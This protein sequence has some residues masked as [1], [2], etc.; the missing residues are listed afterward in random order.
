MDQGNQNDNIWH[1]IH[2]SD[3]SLVLLLR[4]S[5][6]TLAL[7][8]T[9]ETRLHPLLIQSKIPLTNNLRDQGNINFDYLSL[10]K[11]AIQLSWPTIWK[12]DKILRF[13]NQKSN[14]PGLHRR[15]GRRYTNSISS[16]IDNGFTH[17]FD[18]TL[19]FLFL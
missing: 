1:R 16:E 12:G 19:Y 4:F 3:L 7:D 10:L 11:K 8:V 14:Y 17:F 18:K 15:W 13:F 6:M 5:S 2:I 9:L